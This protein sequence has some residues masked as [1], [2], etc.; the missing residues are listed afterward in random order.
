MQ[1]AYFSLSG[2]SGF[3]LYYWC[4]HFMMFLGVVFFTYNQFLGCS[5]LCSGFTDIFVPVSFS[6]SSNLENFGHYMVKYFPSETLIKF[7]LGHLNLPQSSLL[8]IFL[9]HSMFHIVFIAIFQL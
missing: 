2:C 1:Y 3:S 9:L 6:F 4:K 7:I 5:F 8:K